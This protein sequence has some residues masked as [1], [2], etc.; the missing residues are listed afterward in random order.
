MMHTAVKAWALICLTITLAACSGEDLPGFTEFTDLRLSNLEVREGGTLM[1]EEEEVE[2]FNPENTGP[3]HVELNSDAITSFELLAT[4]NNPSQ[5]KLEVVETAK[6]ADG[7]DRITPISSGQALTI[8]V[9]EGSTLIYVQVTSLSS[10]ASVRYNILFNRISSSVELTDLILNGARF[11]LDPTLRESVTEL[12]DDVMRDYLQYPDINLS[13]AVCSVSFRA[14]AASRFAKVAVNGENVTFGEDTLLILPVGRN[15]VTV[16][17]TSEDLQRV[18]HY[19]LYLV[20]AEPTEE[21]RSSDSTLAALSFSSGFQPDPF[22]CDRSA[23]R[24]IVSNSATSVAL[25]AVP[26]QPGAEMWIAAPTFDAQGNPVVVTEGAQR[27]TTGVPF[28]GAL[29]NNLPEGQTLVGIRVDSI[30]GEASRVYLIEIQRAETNQVL[31]S[32]AAQLQQAL[33][34]AVAND[35][36]LV[37]EG[38]YFGETSSAES[39]DG[40]GDPSAHFFSAASGSEERPII[41]RGLDSGAVLLGSSTEMA[42][43]FKL[44]G[45]H[46]RVNNLTFE[47][48]NSGVHIEQAEDI[49]LTVTRVNN[50]VGDGITLDQTADALIS[51]VSID[52]VGG[53]A[54]VLNASNNNA[55]NVFTML[56][57]GKRG[58]VIANGSSNNL[59]QNGGLN[60]IGLTAEASVENGEVPGEGIFVGLGEAIAVGNQISHIAFGRD[61]ANEAIQ[62]SAFATNTKILFNSFSSDNTLDRSVPERSLIVAN[63]SAEISYNDFRVT[64]FENGLDAFESLIN[65]DAGN[66]ADIE[67]FSNNL[68][69]EEAI[70]FASV[71][72]AGS[73]QVADNQGDQDPIFVGPV[74]V[75]ASAPVYQIQSTVDPTTC[76][77]RQ[78][79][80]VTL[81]DSGT[82]VQSPYV[83][84]SPCADSAAQRWRF[85]NEGD[86]YVQIALAADPTLKFDFQTRSFTQQDEAKFAENYLV[87]RKD[88]G[89]N[90]D[91]K[92][93]LRWKID[94]RSDG[95]VSFRSKTQVTVEIVEPDEFDVEEIDA[96]LIFVRQAVAGDTNRFRLIR[97]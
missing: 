50:I 6:E 72:A 71:L 35:E 18:T 91:A 37:S 5:V 24:V 95:T 17:V 9:D 86:G 30:N 51:I 42:S 75:V 41:V 59:F 96:A 44:M 61:I 34:T 79:V 63:S 28:Q 89:S 20:R 14:I 67:I 32:T 83:V 77:E 4:A 97:Q 36:I 58:V 62:A 45:S 84:I 78:D 66:T 26:S 88:L 56:D 40:S 8:N 54:L 52:S 25:T 90:L 39:V 11:V 7:S 70:P 19:R 60:R 46:W 47:R 22:R 38:E 81:L 31:V 94:Y 2:A 10:E 92:F 33:R 93:S 48:A 21:Q 74:N 29:L 82:V 13:Y 68:H 1:F 65:I 27:L 43:V 53:D 69:F 23:A 85:L 80:D 3:Y 73:V 16:R 57:I 15:E 12:E 49:Q 87:P 64:Y 76:L 55:V